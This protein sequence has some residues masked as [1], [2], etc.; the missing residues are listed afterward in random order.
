[1]KLQLLNDI[2]T[3]IKVV[4][5]N[6]FTG[7][8]Q[9]LGISK[10]VASKHISRLEKTLGAQLLHRSTR[11]L[12][13]TEAGRAIYENCSRISDDLDEAERAVSYTHTAPRGVLRITAPSS[14]ASLHLAPAIK[15]FIDAYP[16]IKV[17]VLL[18]PQYRDPLTSGIDVSIQTGSLPDS[19]FMARCI[20]MRSMRVCA[21]PEYLEKHGTPTTPEEL[22][23]HNCLHYVG[24]P[25]GDE[26]SFETD[27][28]P[29]R[30]KI[31]GN[32]STNNSLTL[33]KAAVAGL[34]IVML[35]GF[36]MTKDIK[37]GKLVSLLEEYCPEN[38]G[39]YAVYPFT[40]HVAPKVRVFIDFLAQR[41]A[42]QDY[43]T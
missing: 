39:I 36:M 11:K 25:T 1:M 10:S 9:E 5:N 8:A 16:E 27:T 13:P 34:G 29:A 33:E 41:Y 37:S 35:P 6:S 18:G 4:E 12:T 40:R 2:M 7:A 38:I 26:W 31:R 24:S 32:L 15:D 3:F 17:H 19:N 42:R 43:W 20:A 14:F 21:A 22:Y 23:Q 28:G 30:I